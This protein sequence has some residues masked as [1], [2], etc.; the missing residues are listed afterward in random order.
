MKIPILNLKREYNYQ[1]KDILRSLK[2][3]LKNQ[4]WI[5]GEEVSKLEDLLSKFLKVKYA[6]G[7]ASGTDG[8]ILSL[9]A[10]A[11]KIKGKDF[12]DGDDEI[13]TTP[14][15]FVA[16]GSSILHSGAKP[17]FVDIEPESF[18]INPELIKGAINEKTLGIVLVHLYG[19]PCSL[20][21]ILKICKEKKLFLIED[22]A[23]AIGAKYNGKMVGSFGNLS[24]L[25]FFPSKNLGGYGDGGMVFTREKD[26]YEIV[27]ILRKHG[28]KDKYNAEILGYNSRLDTIQG[29]ILKAKFN[30]LKDFNEKRKK[31][32]SIY[33]KNLRGIKD[34]ALPEQK[35]GV[36]HQFTVR[37]LKNKRDDLKNYLEKKGIQTAIYYP[38]PLHKMKLFQK[39]CK[40]PFPLKESERAS[41]EVLSLPLD[42]LMKEKEIN[43]VIKKIKEFFKING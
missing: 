28:G 4:N 14:F 15:T 20:E 43:F 27:N 16:T 24:A 29:G 5:L 37:V 41:K 31:I 2:E 38:V 13:I 18:N 9:R 36:W 1:K 42:P 7:V 6:I 23:Q 30:Y 22:M 11:I 17:V 26:L 8:L 12:F 40:T 21:E 10:L 34:I 35:G 33:I 25:S 3:A 39:N 19:N 32:A